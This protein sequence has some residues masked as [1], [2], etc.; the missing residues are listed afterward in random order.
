MK[1]KGIKKACSEMNNN[2]TLNRKVMYDQET[3]EVWVD[4]FV[5][6]NSYNQYSSGSI[7]RVLK[8]REG[9][10]NKY[11][12]TTMEEIRNAVEAVCSYAEYYAV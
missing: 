8:K 2:K 4:T 6:E 1:I 5:D 11:E 10:W 7:V 3:G 9:M 12:H